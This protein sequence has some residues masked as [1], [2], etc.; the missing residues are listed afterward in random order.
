MGIHDLAGRALHAL[1]AIPGAL[2]LSW[3]RALGRA[4][5]RV[6]GWL[7]LREARERRCERG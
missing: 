1:A 3:Q 6:V 7:G 4:L 5:G 2:P